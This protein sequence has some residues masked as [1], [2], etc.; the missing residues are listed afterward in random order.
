MSR[1]VVYAM[2]FPSTGEP[3]IIEMDKAAAK[4]LL[5][6]LQKT[7]KDARSKRVANIT[8]QLKRVLAT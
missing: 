8:K 7:P 5:E 3:Y 4:E 1:A 2:E 6:F